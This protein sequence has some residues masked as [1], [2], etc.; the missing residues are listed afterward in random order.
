MVEEPSSIGIRYAGE[1]QPETMSAKELIEILTAFN[2]IVLKASRVVHGSDS[3][4]AFKISHVQAGSIDIK[5]VMEF[6]A[7]LQ[8]LAALTIGAFDV[9]DIPH[10]VKS[11]LDLAKFLAGEPASKVQ[12]VKNGAGLQ[13]E[14][15]NGASSVVNGN[16]Y[17]TYIAVDVGKDAAKLAAPTKRGATKLELI[18]KGRRIAS[19]TPKDA[20]S[21]QPI[22]PNDKPIT[23]EIDAYL[24]VIAPV[25]EGEGGWKLRYGRMVLTAKLED[26]RFLRKVHDGGE[27]FR[28]GD[29]LK[30]RLKTVQ[31][32]VG[33]KVKTKHTIVRVIDRAS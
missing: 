23:T 25:L 22:K 31:T 16:V 29:T 30:V 11:W 13:I 18:G 1:V 26:E 24:S 8:P 6:V 12:N 19:Y 27:S 20:S 21:F 32:R 14:N 3:Q 2:N 33:S 5:G 9:K 4:I 17:N 10:L 15:I 7:G 28:R